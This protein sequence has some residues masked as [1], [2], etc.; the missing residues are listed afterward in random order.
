MSKDFEFGGVKYSYE[1]R[2][3]GDYDNGMTQRITVFND[4]GSI[5]SKDDDATYGYPP[6]HH[7]AKAMEGIARLIARQIVDEYLNLQKK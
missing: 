6:R 4:A 5:G 1:A 2:V 3:S 7:P